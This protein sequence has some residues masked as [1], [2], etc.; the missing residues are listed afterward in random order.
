MIRLLTCLALSAPLI[1]QSEA[2]QNDLEV[3][4]WGT[5]TSMVGADGTVL[6]GLQHEEELLPD[7]VHELTDLSEIN[8]GG[9]RVLKFPAT[10]VTQKMETPVIYFHT[11]T[12]QTVSVDV[13]FPQGLLTQ[14]YPIPF[15]VAP[16]LDEQLRT[17]VDLS[18]VDDAFLRWNVDLIPRD[19]AAPSEIPTCD[20]DDPW[21]FAR[22]VNCAFVRTSDPEGVQRAIEAEHYLFYRGLARFGLPFGLEAG[23]DGTGTFRNECVHAVPF[24]AVLDMNDDGGRFLELGAVGAQSN[25]RFDFDG[26]HRESDRARIAAALGARV[27]EALLDQG[28]FED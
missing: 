21:S 5:F 25:A 16:A 18:Q 3:H 12:A 24:A 19:H 6:E 22:Q 13:R 14:F 17:P 9:G 26:A 15:L 8:G 20:P 4:E 11:G 23:T 7:F 28:L 10:R 2:P 1:G 27:F